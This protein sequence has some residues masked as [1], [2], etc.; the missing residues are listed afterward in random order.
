M[1]RFLLS[2]DTTSGAFHVV[3]DEDGA[4]HAAVF[5]TL[6]DVQERLAADERG[7]LAP[8]QDERLRERFTAYFAGD[9]TAVDDLPVR[10]SGG[11]Y[12]QR[13]WAAMRQIPAGETRSYAQL[14]AELGSASGARAVASACA[15]NRVAV[16]VPCHRVVRSGGSLSGYRWGVPLKEAPLPLEADATL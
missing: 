2:L 16:V 13:V 6:N 14:A 15:N 12:F 8:S 9:V 7:P 5:G 10:Q 1:T 11:P 4:L 3:H